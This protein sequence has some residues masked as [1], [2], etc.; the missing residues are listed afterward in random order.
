MP[1]RRPSECGVLLT[2]RK[3]SYILWMG[4]QMAGREMSQKRKKAIKSFVVVPEDSGKWLADG[5][6]S[7]K[8][9][10]KRPLGT[11]GYCLQTATSP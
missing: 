10:T 8:T 3:T 2:D 6:L 11:Y 1:A 9:R 5:W 4:N 7:S